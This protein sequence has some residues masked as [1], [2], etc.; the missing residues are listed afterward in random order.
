MLLRGTRS[1]SSRPRVRLIPSW[2][3]QQRVACRN[4]TPPAVAATGSRIDILPAL[5]GEDSH[6]RTAPRWVGSFRFV[7]GPGPCRGFKPIAERSPLAM[8][9][10]RYSYPRNDGSHH[11]L[12]AC[13]VRRRIRRYLRRYRYRRLPTGDRR[14]SVGCIRVCP[15]VPAGAR[16]CRVG[17]LTKCVEGTYGLASH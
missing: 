9:N 8:S 14:A 11:F 7:E 2:P 1:C 12:E 5:K 15:I 13:A 3:D 6:A 4:R 16:T 10:G 17:Y